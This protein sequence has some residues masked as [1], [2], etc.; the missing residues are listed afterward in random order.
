MMTIIIMM[1]VMMMI[2][3]VLRASVKCIGCIF[4]PRPG[5]PSLQSI[6]HWD[7]KVAYVDIYLI[8][9]NIHSIHNQTTSI[10]HHHLYHYICHNINLIH[11]QST[12]I[13]SEMIESLNKDLAEITGFA[14]VS[15][16]PNSGAQVRNWRFMCLYSYKM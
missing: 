13:Q 14:A 15:T 1:I 16:Q 11:T 7:T 6:S 9:R 3:V 12:L 4:Y 5:I 10:R 8:C 2:V